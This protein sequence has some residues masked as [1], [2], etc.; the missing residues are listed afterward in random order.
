MET[1]FYYFILFIF[2]SFC[3]WCMEEVVC[4]IAA[5][6]IANRGFLIGP[7]CPIYGYASIF[8]ILLLNRYNDD[9]FAL[10]IMSAVLC[11]VLE[12]LTSLAMEKLF[13]ARWWDYSNRKFNINGRVCLVNSIFFGILGC[14]LIHYINP[15]ITSLLDGFSSTTIYI[16]GGSLFTIFLVDT[17]ISFIVMFKFKF[18]TD[19]LYQDHTEEIAEEITSRLRDILSKKSFLHRRL[20]TAFPNMHAVLKKQKQKLERFIDEKKIEIDEK[21]AILKNKVTREQEKLRNLIKT[22]STSEIVKKYKRKKDN[23]G[24]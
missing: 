2:Y 5:K 7:Y 20:L 11:T 12:Y 4:S 9:M 6:K 18:T 3:G 16:L 22:K 14:L 15:F 1:F 8:M 23:H 17:I 21:Q 19:N 13:H 24:N 10:F